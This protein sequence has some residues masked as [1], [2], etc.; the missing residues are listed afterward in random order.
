VEGELTS[1]RM[2]GPTEARDMNLTVDLPEG[3]NID[4]DD[5]EEKSQNENVH[6]VTLNSENLTKGRVFIAIHWRNYAERPIFINA[7]I[8]DA[9]MNYGDNYEAYY[10][11][12]Q[13]T[14]EIDG[15]NVT[16]F[17]YIPRNLNVLLATGYAIDDR[18]YTRIFA[19][20]LTNDTIQILD[21][22]HI[23]PAKAETEIGQILSSYAT[24]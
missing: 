18:T 16:A 2:Y 6:V 8:N 12:N 1:I 4:I 11:P 23:E 13:F 17:A 10:P 3:W 24:K 5:P 14:T 20:T 19:D 21:T 9:N 15:H 22:L 7:A